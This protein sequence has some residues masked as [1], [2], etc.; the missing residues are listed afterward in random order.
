[1]VSM[2]LIYLHDKN[3]LRFN[4]STTGHFS[5][6]VWFLFTFS[7]L[8]CVSC[9][10]LIHVGL[11]NTHRLLRSTPYLVQNWKGQ[12]ACMFYLLG[13]CNSSEPL[14]ISTVYRREKSAWKKYILFGF[15]GLY[16]SKI[17]RTLSSL[18][19]RSSKDH[20]STTPRPEQNLKSIL[21]SY[22]E[23]KV[24]TT[25][26]LILDCI[27]LL[28]KLPGQYYSHA[29]GNVDNLGSNKEIQLCDLLHM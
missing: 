3:I 7:Y 23:D 10:R 29:P 18:F 21:G 1:M 20:W 27:S 4:H 8:Y 17:L 26:I 15:H 12:H 25:I 11:C 19:R 14:P 28:P 22:S 9:F 6:A 2:I 5:F 13:L 16:T 24:R